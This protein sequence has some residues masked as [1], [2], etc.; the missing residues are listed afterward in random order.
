MSELPN[1][2]VGGLGFFLHKTFLKQVLK[3]FYKVSHDNKAKY[4]LTLDF[5]YSAK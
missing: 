5:K 1:Q 3:F 2:K 4:S